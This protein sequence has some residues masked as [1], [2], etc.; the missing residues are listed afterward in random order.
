MATDE[1]LNLDDR[2][3]RAEAMDLS[4]EEIERD[5]REGM[6]FNAVMCFLG[7]MVTLAGGLLVFVIGHALVRAVWP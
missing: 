7:F 6:R 5:R 4:A 2:F 3:R 1:F